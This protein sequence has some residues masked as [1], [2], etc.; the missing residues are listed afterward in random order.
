MPPD[1]STLQPVPAKLAD[2]PPDVLERARRVAKREL[3]MFPLEAIVATGAVQLYRSGP[4]L[5]VVF[6]GALE[7]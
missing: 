2:L 6:P 1:L 3:P 7:C 4:D 5:V